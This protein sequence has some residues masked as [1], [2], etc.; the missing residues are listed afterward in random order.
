ML[1]LQQFLCVMCP[2]SAK[3]DIL[4]FAA[5]D[6]ALL[7]WIV[8]NRQSSVMLDAIMCVLFPFTADPRQYLATKIWSFC[9]NERQTDVTSEMR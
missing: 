3:P 9:V 7:S 5:V 1:A 6:G 2:S 4:I 8:S